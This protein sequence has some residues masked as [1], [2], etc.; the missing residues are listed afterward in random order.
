[1]SLSNAGPAHRKKYLISIH[2]QTLL[3]V[4]ELKSKEAVLIRRLQQVDQN[5]VHRFCGYNSLYQ[6]CLK[7]LEL[8]ENQAC[9]YIRVAR[10]ALELPELQQD[11]NSGVLSVSKARRIIPVADQDNYREWSQKAK[12]M[13]K[14][15][16]EKAIAQINPKY[17][18]PDHFK[19]VADNLIHM[20]GAITE[21][22]LEKLNRAKEI[23]SQKNKEMVKLNDILDSA[24]NEFLFRH[25]P[26]EKAKRQRVKRQNKKSISTQEVKGFTGQ[27]GPGREG[28]ALSG[29]DNKAS[30]INVSGVNGVNVKRV[31]GVLKVKKKSRVLR[32]S[33]SSHRLAI[34]SHIKYKVLERD[35]YCC[36]WTY[37]DGSRCKERHFIELRHK[38]PYSHGG[39][40]SEDNLL[41]L[42]HG[43]HV[44]HHESLKVGFQSR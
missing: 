31:N 27:P 15:E 17:N 23:L 32:G 18:V 26:K 30:S 8:T 4:K 41:V 28:D 14:R 12:S 37:P 5:K 22:V 2:R 43:H 11:I 25:D 19:P 13:S 33:K 29:Q 35:Q 9:D 24:L 38:I 20:Q 44:A 1:M 10:K 34:P 40:H 42:C 36:Q 21:E 7:A 16:L 6:Y 3:A 39:D